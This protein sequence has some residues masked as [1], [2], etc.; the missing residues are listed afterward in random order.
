[1]KKIYNITW[2]ITAQIGPF[3][4]NSFVFEIIGSG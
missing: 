3:W 1:M 2:Q 4:F